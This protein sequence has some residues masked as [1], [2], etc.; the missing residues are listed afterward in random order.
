MSNNDHIIRNMIDR[1]IADHL[2]WISTLEQAIEKR[3]ALMA[4]NDA[5]SDIHCA[6]CRWLYSADFPER[7]RT[8]PFFVDVCDLHAVF[9]TKAAG[10]LAAI[11]NS[12]ENDRN[13]IPELIRTYLK[14]SY[15]LVALLEN[16]KDAIA[17]DFYPEV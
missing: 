16:W 14:T 8:S 7:L 5:E 9:H 4:V 17:S 15:E 11:I 12:N 13:S 2:L 10:V 6:L 1:A 3:T